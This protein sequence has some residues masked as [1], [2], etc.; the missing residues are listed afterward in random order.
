MNGTPNYQRGYKLQELHSREG[1]EAQPLRLPHLGQCVDIC[2]GAGRDCSTQRGNSL[3]TTELRPRTSSLP[4]FLPVSWLWIYSESLLDFIVELFLRLAEL[5][6][7]PL[8]S[9]FA[10]AYYP[11]ML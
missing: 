1:P 10:V 9:D 3:N 2:M 6:R 4:H 7:V 5:Y 11:L 8:R